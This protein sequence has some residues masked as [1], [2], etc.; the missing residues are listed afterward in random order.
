MTGEAV[1]A[2][3]M[4]G[5]AAS[6]GEILLDRGTYNLVRSAVDVEPAEPID[7]RLTA[8]PMNAF[9]LLAVTPGVRGHARRFDTPLIGRDREL[10]QLNAALNQVALEARCQ[11]FSILGPAGVG[12]SR[13]VH[14]FLRSVRSR[15]LVLRGRCLPY[16]E[17]AALWPVAE[18]IRQAAEIGTT[19]T[20][21][22]PAQRSPTLLVGYPRASVIA[23]RVAALVGA[24]EAPSTSEETSWA[25]RCVF[26]A[27]ARR[28]PIVVVFD[29]VQWGEPPFLDLVE[30]VADNSRSAPILLLCIAR[31]ELLDVRPIGRVAS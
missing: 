31:P 14:E 22:L 26:E 2:A 1:N 16:D 11:L 9:R 15:A 3:T 18:T 27:I 4:L 30:S 28:R 29:D 19:T 24:S 7:G 17:R 23:G 5:L 12:K 21:I 25:V 8:G 6:A 10:R 13:L 20:A